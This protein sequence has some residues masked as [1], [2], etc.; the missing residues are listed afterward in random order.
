M[1]TRIRRLVPKLLIMAVCGGICFMTFKGKISIWWYL[2][3]AIL[4][5]IAIAT[6]IYSGV[7]ATMAF[8][9]LLLAVLDLYL[10]PVLFKNTV[11]VNKKEVLVEFGLL[12]KTLPVQEILVVRKMKSYSA[13]FAADFDRVGIESRRKSTV[14]VSVY[15]ADAMINELKKRNS[16]IKY[17]L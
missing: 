16:K 11:T 9:L 12:K 1:C 8:S 13:S 14:F 6:L 10:I 2:A 3:I 4:N 15:E 5:G 7:S 17:V